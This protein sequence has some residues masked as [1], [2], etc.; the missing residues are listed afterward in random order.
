M[1]CGSVVKDKRG[2]GDR[3]DSVEWTSTQGR[4]VGNT[5]GRWKKESEKEWTGRQEPG[6]AW[7]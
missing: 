5:R 3:G 6:P 1:G 2:C 4:A 7:E